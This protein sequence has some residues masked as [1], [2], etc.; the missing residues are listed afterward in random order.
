M[1]P[2]DFSYASKPGLT[3][4]GDAAHLMTPFAGEGVNLAMLDAVDLSEAI[5]TAANGEEKDLSEAV[6]G[7][8]T[9]MLERSRGSMERTWHNLELFFQDDAP[10]AFVREF[11]EMMRE[12]GGGG[13]TPGSGG[14][15]VPDLKA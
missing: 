4:L 7:Y 2:P 6:K 9:Q 3:L 10:R 8:E 14:P 13:G 5:I 11:Q 12:H 15:D 1:L